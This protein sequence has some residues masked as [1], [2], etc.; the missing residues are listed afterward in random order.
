MTLKKKSNPGK[1]AVPSL[2]KGIEFPCVLRDTGSSVSILPKADDS[3]HENFVV[4]IKLPETRSDEYDEDY[5]REKNNEYHGLAMDDRGLLHTSSADWTDLEGQARAMDGCILNI[6]KEVIADIIVMN[7]SSKLFNSKKRTDDPSSIDDAAPPSIN[8]HFK[9]KRNDYHSKRLNDVYYPFD[10]SISWL[11]TRTDEMKQPSHA[12]EKQQK[13]SKSIDAHTQPSIDARIQASI[14]ARLAPLGDR[15][16]TLTYRFEGVDFLTTRLD[17]L[18][19][20]MDTIQRQLDSQAEPSPSIDSRTPPS[21]DDDYAA[22]RS[23]LVTEK[24]L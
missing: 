7:G 15:L 22:R 10:N 11:T 17:A 24:S 20:E 21:I 18:H 9:S 6:S 12:S 19:Q 8:S 23:K 16:Q 13:I 3:L 2:V 14:Y 5:H 1:F 4:D